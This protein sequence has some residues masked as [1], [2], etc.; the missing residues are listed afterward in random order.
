MPGAGDLDCFLRFEQRE[1]FAAPDRYG[2]TQGGFE[3]RFSTW[4]AVTPMKGGEQTIAGRLAGT[5]PV[6]IQ[7]RR[8]TRTRAITA[9]WRA[10]DVRS[11]AVYSIKSPPVDMDG[12]RA[13]LDML[14]V[15]EDGG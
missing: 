10:V 14:A 11:G 9:D 15:H 7:V 8:S 12:N 4:A 1:G 2:N 3:E 13:F 5:Q 6:V